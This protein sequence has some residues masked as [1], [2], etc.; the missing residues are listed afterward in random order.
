MDPDLQF[1]MIDNE[2]VECDEIKIL[3]KSTLW[4]YQ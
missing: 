1:L 3:L 4:K 2:P